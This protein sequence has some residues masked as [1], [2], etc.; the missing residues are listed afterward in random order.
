MHDFLE[1]E[2]K[3]TILKETFEM[4]TGGNRLLGKLFKKSPELE[5]P[6]A[7][8]VLAAGEVISLLLGKPA[9]ELPDEL[10]KNIMF[11]PAHED[12]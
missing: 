5:E 9:T 12:R 11:C 6:E 7:A 8:A 2:D 10:R 1:S 4:A 3:M